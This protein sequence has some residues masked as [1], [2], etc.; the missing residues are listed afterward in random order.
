MFEEFINLRQDKNGY[1]RLFFTK[2]MDLYIWYDKKDGEIIGFQIVYE[3]NN[4][5][6]AFTWKKENGFT[7]DTV[8]DGDKYFNL[9]PILIPDGEVK[10]SYLISYLESN[11]EIGEA[12]I[13]E[14]VLRKLNEYR[15]KI[16]SR[17]PGH[18]P[19]LL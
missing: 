8:D 4:E 10:L 18:K 17:I 6:K 14:I 5:Q 2:N 7:H 16:V 11:L 19:Y 12:D 9:T 13:K 3:K 15:E 1:R